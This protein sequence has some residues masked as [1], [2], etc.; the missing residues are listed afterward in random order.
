LSAQ[1]GSIQYVIY[2]ALTGKYFRNTGYGGR[3]HDQPKLFMR[4]GD[5]VACMKAQ[6]EWAAVLI[7]PVKVVAL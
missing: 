6:P 3:W 7:L 4:R 1:I 5:A 2:D